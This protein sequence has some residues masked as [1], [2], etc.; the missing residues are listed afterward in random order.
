MSEDDTIEAC[1][2]YILHELSKNSATTQYFIE[3]CNNE[4]RR[5]ISRA[6]RELTE[7]K[8]VIRS[9]NIFKLRENNE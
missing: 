1:K 2:G 3:G 9:G 5:E 4:D 7:S 6:L 8:E